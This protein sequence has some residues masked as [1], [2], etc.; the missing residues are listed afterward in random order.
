MFERDNECPRKPL[1]CKFYALVSFASSIVERAW[2]N[3]N[4]LFCDQSGVTSHLG[5]YVN[6]AVIWEIDVMELWKGP[7]NIKVIQAKW[8]E[9]QKL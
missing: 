6:A 4:L 5:V 8:L 2:H 9:N 1:T 3:M 7:C